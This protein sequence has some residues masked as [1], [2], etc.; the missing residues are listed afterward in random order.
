M[1]LKTALFLLL[2]V[3]VVAPLLAFLFVRWHQVA[4][5]APNVDFTDFGRYVTA[6][7]L[8]HDP[9]AAKIRQQVADGP[10]ELAR[11]KAAAQADGIDLDPAHLQK[12]LPPADQN[13]ALL[14][15]RWYALRKAAKADLPLYAEPMRYG[16]AYT[17]QQI[18]RVQKI[19]DDHRD[20]VA[21][22]HQ[23]ADSPQCVW[24][25]DWQKIP[26][27]AQKPPEF[28]P[29]DYL[30]WGGWKT[31]A[32][33]RT[34][35]TES[36]LLALQG[37][38]TEAIVNQ[39]RG[40]RI[41]AH[42]AAEP[43]LT[44]AT[45]GGAVEAITLTGMVNILDLA[46]PN[47]AVAA[48]VRQAIA[49]HPFHPS[50]KQALAGEAALVPLKMTGV[51]AMTP[52]QLAGYLPG[53]T[54]PSADDSDFPTHFSP[55]VQRFFS[56]AVDAAEAQELNHLHRLY[57]A[58]GTPRDARQQFRKELDA[59]EAAAPDPEKQPNPVIA[60]TALDFSEDDTA[61]DEACDFTDGIQTEEQMLMAVTEALGTKARSGAFPA[62]LTGRYPDAFAD[63][64]PLQ[65][66]QEGANGFVAY[67][68]GPTGH[69]DGGKPGGKAPDW[70]TVMFRYPPAAR[71]KV[72]PDMLK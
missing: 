24:I 3:V 40:F 37:R 64:K 61:F 2:I 1:R 68:V 56:N 58:A 20:V 53:S 70:P 12:P 54:M 22:L 57:T 41:A 43:T 7:N 31:R 50:L 35:N 36:F 42:T 23:A 9:V 55:E 34:I 63:G 62:H 59:S 29:N 28:S 49:A 46:G 48:Q 60:L 11:E 30:L 69:F 27:S 67:S 51:R 25:V 65:Y 47:P 72:P 26:K 39:T 33:A 8:S 19:L 4:S 15:E 5:P 6:L 71:T 44:G 16:Y 32:A 45:V 17:P 18:A 21:L 13:A 52:A 10:A 66:R 14:Y 38:Y